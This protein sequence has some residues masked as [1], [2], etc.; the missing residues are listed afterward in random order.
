MDPE[1]QEPLFYI[2]KP[3]VFEL[4]KINMGGN[5]IIARICVFLGACVLITALVPIRKLIRRLPPG[6]VRLSWI[7]LIVLTLFFV[8]GYAAYGI[9]FLGNQ[10]G[11]ADLI[12]PSIFLSGSVFVLLSSVLSL[13]TAADIRRVTMLEQENVTDPLTGIFNRRYLDRRV[14]EEFARAE[15]YR[16]PLSIILIGLDNFAAVNEEY[17]HVAA[18]SA[19]VSFARMM[20]GVIRPVDVIA[21]YAGVEFMV[22]ATNTPGPEAYELAEKIRK[23]AETHAL[24]MV[25]EYKK[26]LSIRM[27]TSIGVASYDKKFA[28]VQAFVDCAGLMMDQAR[29]EGHNRVVLVEE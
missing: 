25:D 3:A 29:R 20:E 6:K 5:L 19:L 21:R 15:R 1:A 7:L 26:Q 2:Q 11:S 14:H 9:I 28:S 18:D 27:T 12:V 13:R 10:P 23:T 24:E 4:R 22:V 8:I 17:G 16:Q